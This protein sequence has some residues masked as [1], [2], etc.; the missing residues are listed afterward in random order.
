M[1]SI[2][3]GSTAAIIVLVICT[4]KVRNEVIQKAY[5]NYGYTLSEIARHLGL[6]YAIIGRIIKKEMF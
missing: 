6:R 4:K 2:P 5:F 3:S 1:L